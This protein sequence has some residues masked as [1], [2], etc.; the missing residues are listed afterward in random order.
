MVKRRSEEIKVSMGEQRRA[1]REV[2]ESVMSINRH[3][4]GNAQSAEAISEFDE[5]DHTSY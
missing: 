2:T 5:R 1:T 3:T 4:Q